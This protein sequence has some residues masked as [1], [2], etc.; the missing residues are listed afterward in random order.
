MI[1]V[2]KI[3]TQV[4]LSKDVIVPAYNSYFFILDMKVHEKSQNCNIAL[5]YD[6]L[7]LYAYACT[8]ENFFNFFIDWV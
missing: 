5:F 4:S 2:L 7:R 8:A 1:S 6:F 3:I